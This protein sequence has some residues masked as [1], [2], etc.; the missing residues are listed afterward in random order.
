MSFSKNARAVLFALPAFINLAGIARYRHVLYDGESAAFWF[1]CAALLSA[2]FYLALSRRRELF[3]WDELRSRLAAAG[4]ALWGFYLLLFYRGFTYWLLD[5]FFFV[6]ALCLWLGRGRAVFLIASTGILAVIGIR[7]AGNWHLVVLLNLLLLA[8]VFS[9]GGRWLEARLVRQAGGESPKPAQRRAGR[10]Q[11][12]ITVLLFAVLAVYVAPQLLIMVNPRKR[13]RLLESL[14]PAFPVK[15]PA[16]LSPLASGLRAHVIELAGKTGERSAYLPQAQ[17]E[18]GDYVF[19]Q[20]QAA[21]YAPEALEYAAGRANDFGRTKPYYNIEARLAAGRGDCQGVWVLSAH[22]DTAPGTPGADDNA[23]GVA[24]LLEAARLLRA[25]APAREIRFAAFSTEEPP[26]FGTRD[27]GSYRYARYLKSRGVKVYG[28]LNLEMLGYYNDKPSSQ[29]FPPFL[30]LLYP[31]RGNFVA[32]AGNLSS[33]GLLRSVRK[34]WRRNS[35]FPLEAVVLPSVL[36][37]LFI[38]DQLNFWFTGE[39]A[40][41]LSDTSFFRYPYYHQAG[42]TPEKL[43]YERMAEVTRAVVS[44]LAEKQ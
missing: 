20:L 37:T 18:A 6:L 4:C 8:A 23:S 14:E 16:A 36:S 41:M 2:L 10:L 38:S 40:L 5:I 25:R 26:A 17:A 44:V 39:R 33:F 11:L 12:F 27:M 42:D 22:Y 15:P 13:D 21:G 19:K 43:D 32:L 29:L 30:G 24:V 7:H 1:G 31:D 28:M 3:F 34:S 9:G 35:A